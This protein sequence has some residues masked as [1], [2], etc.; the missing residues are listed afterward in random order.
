MAL[1]DDDVLKKNLESPDEFIRSFD[2]GKYPMLIEADEF[3]KRI[4][5]KPENWKIVDWYWNSVKNKKVDFIVIETNWEDWIVFWENH[6]YLSN[7]KNVNYAWQV[8]FDSNWNINWWS[9]GSWHYKPNKNDLE[10]IQKF[11]NAFYNRFEKDFIWD[12]N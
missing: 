10:W 4:V 11:K 1:M 9:N 8:E 3:W 7:W 12:I 2:D 5:L 6:S